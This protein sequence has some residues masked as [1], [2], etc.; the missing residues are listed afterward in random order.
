M[1]PEEALEEQE[2]ELEALE[3]I[4]MEDYCLLS[5]E[6]STPAKF[7]IRVVPVQG[8]ND[9]EEG[10]NHVAVHL[11]IQY[12]TL[13]PSEVPIITVENEFGLSDVQLEEIKSVSVGA[14]EEN[15]G[16]VMAYSIADAVCEWLQENNRPA[17]D[18]SAFSEMQERARIEKDKADEK[19][20]KRVE[21]ETA[22]KKAHNLTEAGQRKH[23]GT[24]VTVAT[25]NE[26]NKKFMD[27]INAK[28]LAE[29]ERIKALSSGN[30][31]GQ[32]ES[33]AD[34]LARPTGKSLF[35]Q[36]VSILLDAEKIIE[37]EM[38]KQYAAAASRVQEQ[39]QESGEG[40]EKA[41]SAPVSRGAIDK[42]LFLAGDDGELCD[43]DDLDDD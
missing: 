28:E 5:P 10:G 26:W 16:Q 27:E 13:Y 3:S 11:I 7:Q 15:V 9:N 40:E 20:K 33:D 41:P 1:D 17:S 38:A 36:D 23:H 4:Y 12:T 6:G 37:E 21:E 34:I 43:L 30:K 32:G 39:Q 31:G 18:G 24:P 35:A 14:A 19:E 42:S 2:M 8:G 25:F 22:A 29:S